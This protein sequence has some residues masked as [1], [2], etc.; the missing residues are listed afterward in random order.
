[1]KIVTQ[2]DIARRL[3]CS[4][5]AV[6]FA[7]NNYRNSKVSLRPEKRQLIL[8]TATKL[9]YVPNRAARRLT[10]ARFRKPVNEMDLV[11]LIYFGS[12][13]VDLDPVCIAMMSGAEHE[14]SKFHASLTF[15]RAG[16]SSD[17]EKVER[18][19][20]AGSVDGWL[21]VGPVTDEV[22]DHLKPG[23]LPF[24]ILGDHRC[25]QPVHAVNVDHMAAG[26]L[27]VQH[28]ASLGHR[29]IACLG[30]GM[31]YL[32]QRQTLE[33]FR[34]AIKEFGL[35]DDERLLGD[36]STWKNVVGK[37]IMDWLREPDPRPTAVFFSE[38]GM[39]FELCQILKDLG[40]EVPGEISVLGFGSPFP[41]AKRGNIT[42]IELPMNEVGCQGALLLQRIAAALPHSFGTQVEP[43]LDSR[44]GF[45]E[46]KISP[47]LIEGRSTQSRQNDESKN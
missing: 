13:D 6:G 26:R 43:G 46:I 24:V 45:S 5:Q 25:T 17:W 35:D 16:E 32:Y 40:L 8:E 22:V 1:M 10:R 42:Y 31:Q 38:P 44:M 19:E 34:S 27:A 21:L 9:G 2:A 3:G 47:S 36:C 30:T 11:G 39:A 4:Q 23:K 33:G 15:V 20:R 7:L 28:L 41:G 18:L 29:R 37:D 12:A 14:L